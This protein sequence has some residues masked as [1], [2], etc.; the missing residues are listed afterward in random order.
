MRLVRILFLLAIAIIYVAARPK[1]LDISFDLHTVSHEHME[2]ARFHT[3]AGIKKIELDY[4]KVDKSRMHTVTFAIKQR[5]VNKLHDILMDVSNPSSNNYGKHWSKARV[6]RY[7]S[8]MGS[9]NAVKQVL[10]SLGITIES[11]TPFGEYL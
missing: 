10:E 7:T 11:V 8:N 4:L 2:K 6:G 5:N 3:Q 1:T 9:T